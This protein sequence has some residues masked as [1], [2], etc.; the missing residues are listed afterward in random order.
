MKGAAKLCEPEIVA[1][2]MG[3]ATQGAATYIRVSG[4]M[5]DNLVF[6]APT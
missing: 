3:E 6:T 1:N 5:S 4:W 2:D